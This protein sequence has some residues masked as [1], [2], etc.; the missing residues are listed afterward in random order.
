MMNPRE[1]ISNIT[2]KPN[3]FSLKELMGEQ[4]YYAWLAEKYPNITSQVSREQQANQFAAILDF[5]IRIQMCIYRRMEYHKEELKEFFERMQNEDIIYSRQRAE[6]IEHMSKMEKAQAQKIVDLMQAFSDEKNKKEKLNEILKLIETQIRETQLKIDE[7]KLILQK[8]NT[9]IDQFNVKIDARIQVHIEDAVF[10]SQLLPNDHPNA[11]EHKRQIDNAISNLRNGSLPLANFHEEVANIAKNYLDIVPQMASRLERFEK[12]IA[13]TTELIELRD[14]LVVKREDV[15]EEIKVLEEEKGVLNNAKSAILNEILAL[16][17]PQKNEN[18]SPAAGSSQ[19]IANMFAKAEFKEQSELAN[20][21][22]QIDNMAKTIEAMLDKNNG[23]DNDGQSDDDLLASLLGDID[24][25]DKLLEEEPD[26][27]SI[28]TYEQGLSDPEFNPQI[29][30]EASKPIDELP[31]YSEQKE[32]ISD[33]KNVEVA[34]GHNE[35]REASER[36]RSNR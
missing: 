14:Q 17:Q 35:E 32:N 5:E 9:S 22:F 6:L 18:N 2:L 12:G 34:A 24:E 19:A 26:L 15:K 33:E 23:N 1:N 3:L 29:H 25:A 30:E 8:L 10:I 36:P 11:S 7:Q 4:A 28:K 27:V 21:E 13:K 20:T 16:S 31:I